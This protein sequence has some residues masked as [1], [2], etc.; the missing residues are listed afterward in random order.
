MRPG[1]FLGFYFWLDAI[2]TSSLVFEVPSVRHKFFSGGSEYIN[3]QNTGG[4]IDNAGDILY[5]SSKA[6]R[7]ARVSHRSR[8]WI[9]ARVGGLCR[10]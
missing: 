7:V 3:L 10:R 9:L 2:A 5:N 6:G 8:A 1:Y 4:F